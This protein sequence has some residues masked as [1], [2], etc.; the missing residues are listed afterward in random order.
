MGTGPRSQ[1][2]KGI[3]KEICLRTP[4]QSLVKR[5]LELKTQ[6]GKGQVLLNSYFEGNMM[7]YMKAETGFGKL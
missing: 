7:E 6:W 3:S 4:Y 5:R 2:V 1:F